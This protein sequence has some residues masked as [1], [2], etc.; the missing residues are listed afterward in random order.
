MDKFFKFWNKKRL[1]TGGLV[2]LLILLICKLV[3]FLIMEN[4]LENKFAEFIFSFFYVLVFIAL[5]FIFIFGI[6]LLVKLL[7][8]IFK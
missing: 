7:R 6:F 1:I 2:S 8:F 5:F 4:D 3:I